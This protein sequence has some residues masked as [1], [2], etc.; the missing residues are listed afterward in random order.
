MNDLIDAY[1]ENVY[2]EAAPYMMQAFNE[3]R[4]WFNR[5]YTEQSWSS[6][7]IGY[8]PTA[9]STYWDIGFVTKMFAYLDKAYAAIEPY[10]KDAET[11][12]LIRRYIDLEWLFP[13]K[14]A[15]S[16]FE[17]EFTTQDFADI[18]AKF[19]RVCGEHA[20]TALNEFDGLDSFLNTL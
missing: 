19:K 9:T 1:M 14:V 10:K 12:D 15:I 2:K 17:G 20:I 11:Y 8:N 3:S 13:A 4:A 16:N 18:K 7:I 6:G 5:T